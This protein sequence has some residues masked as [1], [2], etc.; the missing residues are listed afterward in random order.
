MNELPLGSYFQ[1]FGA[2][3]TGIAAV[4]LFELNDKKSII[5]LSILMICAGITPVSR[6]ILPKPYCTA[7][8]VF[9]LQTTGKTIEMLNSP[10]KKSTQVLPSTSLELIDFARKSGG[11]LK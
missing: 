11:N 1:V 9:H 6:M 7:E 3:L 8:L 5:V 2:A 10:G 4:V